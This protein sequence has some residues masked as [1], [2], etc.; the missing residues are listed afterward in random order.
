MNKK[1]KF[2]KQSLSDYSS[3]RRLAFPPTFL[4]LIT[5]TMSRVL[6]RIKKTNV[7]GIV[8]EAVAVSVFLCVYIPTIIIGD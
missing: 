2:A 8:V 5:L 6:L 7:L 1:G 3:Y 4:L